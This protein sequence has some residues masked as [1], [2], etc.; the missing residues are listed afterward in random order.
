MLETQA[1]T[2]TRYMIQRESRFENDSDVSILSSD[3][4]STPSE[5]TLDEICESM[6][7][8][9]QD[10]LDFHSREGSLRY[11]PFGFDR[12]RD[13]HHNSSSIGFGNTMGKVQG[14]IG[15][16]MSRNVVPLNTEVFTQAPH[17]MSIRGDR[18]HIGTLHCTEAR[19]A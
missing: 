3:D 8:H 5:K 1:C 16:V 4:E 9:M 10:L 2:N 15:S 18:F 12:I 6:E 14:V 11:F 13:I 7:G 17:I 19:Q